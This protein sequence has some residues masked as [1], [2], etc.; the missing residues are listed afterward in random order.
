MLLV[1]LLLVPIQGLAAVVHALGCDQHDERAP[2]ASAH[3]HGVPDH[4]ASHHHPDESDG[5]AGSDHSSHQCCHHFSAAPVSTS[6]TAQ[7]NPGVFQSSVALL[8]LS[9]VLE[10]PQRPPRA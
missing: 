1:L 7:I 3:S 6:I 8:D 4:G 9:A 5:G 2:A 10:Q